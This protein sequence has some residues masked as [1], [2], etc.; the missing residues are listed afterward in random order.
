MKKLLTGVA[1]AA[2]LLA[3]VTPAFAGNYNDAYIKDN[4]VTVSANTG[5]NGQTSGDVKAWNSSGATGGDQLV[6][7]G[8]AK[9][10][11]VQAIVANVNVDG[12]EC[13][14]HYNYAKVKYNDVSVSANTGA[15]YQ[16]SGKVKA[17]N[18]SGATGGTQ[19]AVTGEAKAKGKQLVVVNVNADLWS[20]YP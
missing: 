18:S 6:V 19:T 16:T 4:D 5:A 20:M 8:D 3:T 13:A 12:C 10:K 14:S 7:T 9:A 1:S 11:G 15:N 17:W 2:L